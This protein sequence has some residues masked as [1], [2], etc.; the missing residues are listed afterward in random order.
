L[1]ETAAISY[2]MGRGLDFHAARRL[3]ESWEIDEAFPPF[4]GVVHHHHHVVQPY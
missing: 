1:Y 4:E 2:L 3:V